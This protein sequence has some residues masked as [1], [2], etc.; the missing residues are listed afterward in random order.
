MIVYISETETQFPYLSAPGD[1]LTSTVFVY[2]GNT[3]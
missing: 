1:F 3:L 2:S